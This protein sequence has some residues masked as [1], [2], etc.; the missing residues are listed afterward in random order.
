MLYLLEQRRLWGHFGEYL[1]GGRTTRTHL[2]PAPMD[3]ERFGPFVPP[4]Y[5]THI[6][7]L[8]CDSLRRAIERER[9]FKVEFRST[10][11]ERLLPLPWHEWDLNAEQPPLIPS[12]RDPEYYYFDIMDTMSDE[13]REAACAE[14]A[15]T[16][17]RSWELIL[18]VIPCDVTWNQQEGKH[19][20]RLQHQQYKGI[21]Y[22]SKAEVWPLAAQDA[23]DWL[24]AHVGP[25]AH[26]EPLVMRDEN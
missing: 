12:H 8:V 5:T 19:F 24:E 25:W 13:Q 17:E 23:K 16:M 1:I 21:F 15:R 11:Y 26:F 18:P 9:P 22:P 20:V 7:V 4:L 3:L 10:H 2:S 14:L 6:R